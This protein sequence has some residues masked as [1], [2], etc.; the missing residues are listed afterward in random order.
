MTE[1]LT[2][3]D[4]AKDICEEVVSRHFMPVVRYQH[5]KIP[6]MVSAITENVV[7]RLTLEAALP[8]KY[9]AHCVVFQNN[10]AGFNAISACSWNPASDACYVHHAENKA[11][12]C[13][14][15]VYGVV[16]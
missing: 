2:L 14:L 6:A 8:R 13:V 1:K 10:G 5:E 4:D 7:Q 11:M 9:I 16:A 12:H 15:T 3:A